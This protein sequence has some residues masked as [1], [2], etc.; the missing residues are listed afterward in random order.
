MDNCELSLDDLTPKQQAFLAQSGG[1]GPSYMSEEG[2]SCD[3][4][5]MKLHS[6]AR[7]C[8]PEQHFPGSPELQLVNALSNFPI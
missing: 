7:T 6:V 2:D 8:Q 5:K 1:A 4:V 3:V